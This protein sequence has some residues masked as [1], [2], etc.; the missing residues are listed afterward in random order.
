[1]S[2]VFLSTCS[3]VIHTGSLLIARVLQVYSHIIGVDTINQ[4]AYQL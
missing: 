3:H 1:M 2:R 4:Y